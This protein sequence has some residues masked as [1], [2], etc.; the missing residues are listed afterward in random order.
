M[1]KRARIAIRVIVFGLALL[2]LA[3]GLPKI[4]QMPQELE[5]LKV[6]GFSA[7][8]VS[9][10]GVVQV[11]GGILLPWPRTQLV[12]ALLAGVPLAVSTVAIFASGNVVFGLV[13]TV[14]ILLLALVLYFGHRRKSPVGEGALKEQ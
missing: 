7:V 4:M 10:L 8:G 14:P 12:G 1:G 13:S 9:V 11:L 6:I 3:A 2:S 5:F